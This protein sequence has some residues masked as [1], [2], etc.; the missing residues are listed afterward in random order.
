MNFVLKRYTH[1]YKQHSIYYI[2]C[3]YNP[4][5]NYYKGVSLQ[6]RK[7][8]SREKHHINLAGS[9]LKHQIICSCQVYY[10]LFSVLKFVRF[11]AHTAI[12]LFRNSISKPKE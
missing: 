8:R 1:E 9:C 2:L 3:T 10:P 12:G 11:T 7:Q 6:G 4:K 5:F